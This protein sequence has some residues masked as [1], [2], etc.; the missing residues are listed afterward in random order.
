MGQPEKNQVIDVK[1]EETISRKEIIEKYLDSDPKTIDDAIMKDFVQDRLK[2]KMVMAGHSSEL[3]QYLSALQKK[4][5][6]LQVLISDQ[7][8]VMKYIDSKIVER[9]IQLTGI[10][11]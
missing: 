3:K 11:K 1:A 10:G 9:H 6:K 4:A 2:A 7:N 8:G 5:A